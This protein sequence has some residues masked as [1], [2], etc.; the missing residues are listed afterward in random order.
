VSGERSPASEPSVDEGTVGDRV[1]ALRSEG[2]SFASI[3]KAVGLERS[4]DAFTTFVDE[5]AQR[6]PAEQV[7]LRAEENSRLDTLEERTRGRTEASEL[8]RKLAIIVQLRER[9]AAG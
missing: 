6:S 4:M 9:L 2:R 1:V 8:D 7:R 5:V 3:A